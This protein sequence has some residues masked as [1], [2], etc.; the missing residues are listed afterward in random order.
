MLRPPDVVVLIALLHLRDEPWTI[1]SLAQQLHM[2]L[3]GAQRSLAR[4]GETPVFDAATRQVSAFASDELLTHALPFVAPARLGA[5]T[6]GVPTAWGAE[7]LAG[8]LAGGTEVPV[9]P[10]RNGKTRGPALAPLHAAVP[11]LARQDQTMYE[12]LA[13]VD[14]LRVGRA[15][16]RSS[17]LRHLRARL[18]QPAAHG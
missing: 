3:A 14:A 10:D 16:E 7:P 6:R 2:P 1:R 9:W 13:L 15:R 11:E 8:E 18:L 5:P 4:L 17:A 12:S